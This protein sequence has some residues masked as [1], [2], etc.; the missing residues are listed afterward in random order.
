MSN[1]LIYEQNSTK[2]MLKQDGEYGKYVSITGVTIVGATSA[3][4]RGPE[5]FMGS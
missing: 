5:A 4:H 2:R 1:T 3:M